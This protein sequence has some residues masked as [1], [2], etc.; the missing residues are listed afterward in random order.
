MLAGLPLAAQR[1]GMH[2]RMHA[3]VNTI[4]RNSPTGFAVKLKG[5]GSAHADETHFAGRHN[6]P[7]FGQCHALCTLYIT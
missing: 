7:Y 6:P 5:Q 3:R 2:V 4:L 1:V